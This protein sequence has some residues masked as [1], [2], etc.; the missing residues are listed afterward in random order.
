[1]Q[2]WSSRTQSLILSFNTLLFASTQILLFTLFP[3]F[4][5]TFSLSLSTIVATFTVGSAL[6]L[7]GAPYWTAK[8]DL[9]GRQKIMNIGLTGL[10]LSFALISFLIFFKNDFSSTVIFFVLLLSRIIY[11]VT[12][13][14]IVPIAQLMRAEFSEGQQL[15][16][17]FTHSLTL[18]LGRTIGPLLVLLASSRVE[19]LLLLLTLILLT[20]LLVN[21]SKKNETSL[22]SPERTS[23]KAQW[24]R[25]AKE[26]IWPLSITILF[27]SFT[28]ILHSSLGGTLQEVFGLSSIAASTL[29]AQV[30]LAG[31]FTMILVQIFGKTLKALNWRK[32]LLLGVSSL[33]VGTLILLLMNQQ[34][35]IWP[36][37]VFISIGIALVQ[38][39][40]LTFLHETQQGHELGRKV[41][42]LSS[43][44]TIGYA[45]GGTLASV[46]MSF[47]INLVSCFIVGALFAATIISCQR[48]QYANH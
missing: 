3:F 48:F 19:T 8:S 38:P 7:W 1:M 34:Y 47:N 44:N 18:S 46:F 20:L 36:A 4:A 33:S 30:L 12:A 9:W 24:S 17:M 14:A 16:S 11:G 31:S 2:N 32:T 6:F 41:G 45:L 42:L 26:M 28:G 25:S 37:I 13:S 29:M 27:T 10:M 39:G 35:E 21:L 15:K 40:N 43:G 23:S 22:V 5:E